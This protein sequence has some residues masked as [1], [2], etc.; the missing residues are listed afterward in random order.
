MGACTSTTPK[1]PRNTTQSQEAKPETM[2]DVKARR[3]R[4]AAAITSVQENS[5]KLDD[6]INERVE[7]IINDE[8][9]TAKKGTLDSA[10]VVLEYEAK[11]QELRSFQQ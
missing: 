9:F 4:L 7:A 10:K 3:D 11:Q 6:R 5:K 1:P 8:V 2:G